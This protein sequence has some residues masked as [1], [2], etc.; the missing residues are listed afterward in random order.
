MSKSEFGIVAIVGKICLVE[1]TVFDLTIHRG[2]SP[3][4]LRPTALEQ[5]Q[6]QVMKHQNFRLKHEL[7]ASKWL[8]PIGKIWV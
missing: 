3:D 1:I 6:A 4:L 7:D 8:F 5:Q 2:R